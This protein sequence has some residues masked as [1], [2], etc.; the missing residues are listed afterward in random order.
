[1]RIKLDLDE[2]TTNRLVEIALAEK[3]PLAW[4][5]EILVQQAMAQWAMP[6]LRNDVSAVE[7]AGVG[8]KG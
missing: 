6:T 5:L 3:R 8:E 7:P 1:M 2:Q 4:Q